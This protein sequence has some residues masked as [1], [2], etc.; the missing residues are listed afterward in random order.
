M[1]FQDTSRTVLVSRGFWERMPRKD[2]QQRP[3]AYGHGEA[4]RRVAAG[5]ASV[6]GSDATCLCALEASSSREVAQFQKSSSV[7][8]EVIV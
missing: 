3:E 2:E 4:R 1:A 6:H 5:E 7:S 8:G